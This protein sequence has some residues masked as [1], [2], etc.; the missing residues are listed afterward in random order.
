VGTDELAATVAE[1]CGTDQDTARIW[2][3]L[4]VESGREVIE[5][6]GPDVPDLL[7]AA[8]E[9]MRDRLTALCLGW[10]AE[11]RVWRCWLAH[12]TYAHHNG[13]EC[14]KFANDTERATWA[15][16]AT[17]SDPSLADLDRD[18]VSALVAKL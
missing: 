6:A 14:P 7:G 1:K 11:A 5:E 9:R 17:I 4:M 16:E 18:S 12:T 15:M 10:S 3:R 8:H 2:L 13:M